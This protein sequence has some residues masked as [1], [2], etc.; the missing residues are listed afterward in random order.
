MAERRP[1][2]VACLGIVAIAIAIRAVPLYWSPL[3]AT[4]D[5]FGY[6]A[7]ARETIASAHY[8]IERFRADNFVFTGLLTVTSLL[9]GV[10]PLG[11]AQPLIAVVGGTSTLTAVAI[12]RRVGWGI[13]PSNRRVRSAAVLA[14]LTLAVDGLYLRRTGVP[15]EEALG[16]VLVPLVAIALHRVLRSGRVAWV[17]ITGTLMLAF[18]LLHTFSTLLAGLTVLGLVAAHLLSSPSRRVMAVGIGLVGGFWAYYALYYELAARFGLTVPYVGRILSYPGLFAAWVIVLV[19]GVLW[20]TGTRSRAQTGVLLGVVGI[21][22]LLLGANAVLPVFPGTISTPLPILVGALLFV[23]PVVVASRGLPVATLGSAD[24]AVVLA[25]L[26]APVVQAYFSLTAALTPQFLGTV[27]RTQTFVHVPIFVLAALVTLRYAPSVAPAR[28]VSSLRGAVT[29]RRL[30]AGA[31]VVTTLLTAPLAFVHLDNA[32]S[33][34]T[35]VESE[36]AAAAFATTHVDGTW[37]ADDPLARIGSLYYP[38]RTA[39]TQAPVTSWLTG[40]TAPSCPT[41]SQRSW[42]TTGAHLYPAPPATIGEARYEDWLAERHLV[43]TT[44]GDDPLSLSIPSRE[45]GRGC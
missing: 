21:W 7:L 40:G 25:L 22:Y 43:Y 44:A 26:A 14:G 20:L 10:T 11:T 18:P 36:F 41:L 12:A 33:P 2:V 39:T 3:P 34:A 30:V 8:P 28:G 15:D 45:T 35:T 6:A 4:L 42:T 27:V 16:L 38:T 37:S 23:V 19:V 9:V 31:L 13:D 17:A 29:S 24:S 1:Y 5:G 32:A